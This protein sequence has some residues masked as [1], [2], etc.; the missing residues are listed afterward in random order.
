MFAVQSGEFGLQ[1][2][3]PTIFIA[4][5]RTS[6]ALIWRFNFSAMIASF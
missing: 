3:L 2:R 1:V 6:R 4:L 5:F